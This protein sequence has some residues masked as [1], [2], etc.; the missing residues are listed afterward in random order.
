MVSVGLFVV[1]PNHTDRFLLLLVS[2]GDRVNF[3]DL[4]NRYVPEEDRIHP[5]VT[6][7][8][9]FVLLGGLNIPLSRPWDVFKVTQNASEIYLSTF[10][11]HLDVVL[12]QKGFQGLV[13]DVLT[14]LFELPIVLV[15]DLFLHT[16][17]IQL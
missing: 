8:A 15:L 6:G 17:C 14:G 9:T 1:I 5:V 16:Q 3:V 4:A 13:V 2:H 7:P 11:V 10:G 12:V